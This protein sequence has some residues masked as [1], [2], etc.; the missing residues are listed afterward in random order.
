MLYH[1]GMDTPIGRLVLVADADGALVRVQFPG[2]RSAPADP[3]TMACDP[4]RLASIRVQFEDWFAGR[5]FA[6]DLPLKPSGTAFQQSVWAAL[7]GIGYGRTASYAQ[8]ARR[9]GRARAVRA[10]GAANGANPLAIVVPCHRVIGADG[11][12]TGYAGGLEAKHWLLEHERRHR[13]EREPGKD[14]W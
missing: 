4:A 6:F 10:V 7:C 12:L 9:I 13:P 11:R 8:I 3:R 2:S 1:D 5:R 14:A